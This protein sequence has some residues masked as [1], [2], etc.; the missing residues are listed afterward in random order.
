VEKINQPETEDM[1]EIVE[2]VVSLAREFIAE[3]P[4]AM[5]DQ[6]RIRACDR[7]AYVYAIGRGGKHAG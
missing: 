1:K 3:Y 4:S 7:L 5:C 6:E 2:L